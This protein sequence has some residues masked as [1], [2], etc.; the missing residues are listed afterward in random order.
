M[1]TFRPIN[2]NRFAMKDKTPVKDYLKAKDF[3]DNRLWKLIAGRLLTCV[4][5]EWMSEFEFNQRFPVP[6]SAYKTI[7]S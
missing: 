2:K 5:G 7:E 3:R 4:N 1:P 6:E